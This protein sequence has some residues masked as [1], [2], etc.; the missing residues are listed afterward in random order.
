MRFRD[1]HQPR[2]LVFRPSEQVSI[3]ATS[4]TKNASTKLKVYANKR[5]TKASQKRIIVRIPKEAL[6]FVTVELD[7]N[8]TGKWDQLHLQRH[9]IEV[10]FRRV[11]RLLWRHRIV[12]GP[13]NSRWIYRLLAVKRRTPIGVCCERTCSARMIPVVFVSRAQPCHSC[14]RKKVIPI[15]TS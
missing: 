2:T 13:S 1:I 9:G 3:E 6:K 11:S 14:G 15:P 4:R 8:F 7:V 12:P 5:L 10:V